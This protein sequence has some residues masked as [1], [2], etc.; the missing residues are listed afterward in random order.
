MEGLNPKDPEQVTGRT[1]S[2]RLTFFPA[3]R[4][5][6]GS[7]QP[8]DLATVRIEEVRACSLSGQAV[9]R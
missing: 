5:G 6:G 2:N 9:D 8:G 7:W 1:R 3:A 4:A